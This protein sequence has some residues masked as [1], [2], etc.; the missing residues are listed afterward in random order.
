MI[1]YN[2]LGIIADRSFA[3]YIRDLHSYLVYRRVRPEHALCPYLINY[4]EGEDDQ[5]Y[6]ENVETLRNHCKGLVEERKKNLDK[7]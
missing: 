5:E 6:L 1:T 3:K 2:N 7:Y 4:Y